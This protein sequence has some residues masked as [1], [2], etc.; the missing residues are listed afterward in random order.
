MEECLD[1]EFHRAKRQGLA[2]AVFMLDIDHF[3]VFNDTYGHDAG[4]ILLSEVGSLL[5][6]SIRAEDVA[7]RYGGEE[8]IIIL[9]AVSKDMAME[10]AENIRG[11][12]S[13]IKVHYREKELGEVRVSVGVALYDEHGTTPE[14]V[15]KAADMALYLAKSQGRD[16]VAL[17]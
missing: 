16:Q 13:K 2:V 14:A 8:F 17:A 1:R 5:K 15:L 9:P 4:D 6:N 7:C 11:M 3:K 12:V 10:R